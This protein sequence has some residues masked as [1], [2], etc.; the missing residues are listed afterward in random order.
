VIDQ[1][2]NGDISNEQNANLST[3]YVKVERVV[4]IVEAIFKMSS[5]LSLFEG[6]QMLEVPFSTL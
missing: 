5:A 3:L 1:V 6:T 4:D 2:V